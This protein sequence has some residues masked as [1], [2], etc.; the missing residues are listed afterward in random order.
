MALAKNISPPGP[1]VAFGPA[2]LTFVT[3][4]RGED[5][6]DDLNENERGK[7]SKDMMGSSQRGVPVLS[8]G[9]DL[10]LIHI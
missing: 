3:R 1:G 10:S 5:V 8:V 9:E 2:L 4:G 6:D 7:A